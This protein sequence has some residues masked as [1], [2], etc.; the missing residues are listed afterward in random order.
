MAQDDHENEA[1][2]ELDP[3]QEE[4]HPSCDLDIIVKKPQKR[5]SDT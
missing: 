5:R 3:S 2:L 4:F 1:P